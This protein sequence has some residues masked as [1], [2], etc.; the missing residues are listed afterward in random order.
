[1]SKY[2]VDSVYKLLEQSR[3]QFERLPHNIDQKWTKAVQ[4]GWY[5]TSYMP[6]H[7]SNKSLSTQENL[8]LRLLDAFEANYS[9]AKD[10]LLNN[11]RDRRHIISVAIDLHESRNYIA[12]IPLFLSQSDGIFEEL[13]GQSVF[14]RRPQNLDK[15]GRKL[16]SIF[17]TDSIRRAIFGLFCKESPYSAKSDSFSKDDKAKSPN[18]NGILH[19][20]YRHLDYGTYMNSCKSICLLS[21]II[22][23]MSAHEEEQTS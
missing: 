23:L 21:S 13:L 3:R 9:E 14:T 11:G 6:F 7:L 12:S 22:W 1:M 10:Y 18:R 16:D 19:G 20:D 2:R 17:E 15:V 8:D 4:L 5:P